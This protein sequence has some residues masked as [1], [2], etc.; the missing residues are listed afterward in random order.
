MK[1]EANNEADKNGFAVQFTDVVCH[2]SA[3]ASHWFPIE[4]THYTSPTNA[5]LANFQP[6]PKPST[7]YNNTQWYMYVM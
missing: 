3:K 4:P 6:T 2:T 5:N 1:V 7:G